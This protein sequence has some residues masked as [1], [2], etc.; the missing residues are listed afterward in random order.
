MAYIYR[1]I[2]HKPDGSTYLSRKWYVRYLDHRGKRIIRAGYPDK[3]ATQHLAVRL[4]REAALRREGLPVPEDPDS[5]RPA[6]LLPGFL[7]HL[8]AK[9]DTEQHVTDCRRRIESILAGTRG[10][11]EGGAVELFLHSRRL[12]GM[13]IGTSNRYLAAMKGFCT[14]L[15]EKRRV[16]T[17]HPLRGVKK[18]KSEAGARVRRALTSEEFGKLLETTKQSKR[19]LGGL[20]GLERHM[21]YLTAAYTGLRAGEIASLTRSNFA[22]GAVTVEAGYSKARRLDT[23]PIPTAIYELIV[24]WARHR[25]PGELWPRRWKDD[26][27]TAEM[28]RADLAAADIAFETPAGRFDFHAFRTQYITELARA[29]VQLAHAQKLARHSTPTLTANYYTRLANTDLAEAVSRLS[30]PAKT[31]T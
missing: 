29:G 24:E 31:V 14:W 16:L 23:V 6:D 30:L 27:H 4:E 25:P 8:R 18:I 19:I 2:R 20:N 28:V 7:N 10:R 13:A 3:Q 21:L 12:E 11:I 1:P 17:E 15:V 22:A 9:G 5:K 26:R